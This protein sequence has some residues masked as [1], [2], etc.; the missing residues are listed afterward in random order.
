MRIEAPRSPDLTVVS[1]Q[2]H[3]ID[4]LKE[5]GHLNRKQ[6]GVFNEA[7]QLAERQRLIR[8]AIVKTSLRIIERL[9]IEW[10]NTV[11]HL[12]KEGKVN[13]EIQRSELGLS[14]PARNQAH[15]LL[16][17]LTGRENFVEGVESL[18]FVVQ[19]SKPQPIQ[20]DEGPI[21]DFHS[22]QLYLIHQRNNLRLNLT[23]DED[24]KTPHAAV[25]FGYTISDPT[26]R[27][28][29]TRVQIIDPTTDQWRALEDAVGFLTLLEKSRPVFP[30]QKPQVK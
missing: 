25:E 8:M 26:V 1:I 17:L 28:M 5:L 10:I 23:W 3:V 21:V 7:A 29:L 11:L 18:E 24:S 30:Q 20:K 15:R 16:V 27:E 9:P 4:S 19:R 6:Q 22:M 14:G 13:L 12:D 2:S